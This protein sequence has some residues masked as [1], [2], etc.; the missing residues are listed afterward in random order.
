MMRYQVFSNV[1][2]SGATVQWEVT[3]RYFRLLS[4]TAALKIATDDAE[5]QVFY[6]GIGA[7]EPDG[8]K[9]LR[10][11]NEKVFAV[12]FELAA[13][14]GPVS[15]SRFTIDGGLPVKAGGAS[16]S[17]AEID[18]SNVAVELLAA[19]AGRTSCVI[20]AGQ[21]GLWLGPTKAVQV[22]A[23]PTVPAGQSLTIGHRGAVWA[24]RAAG[25]A[26]KAGV[27]TEVE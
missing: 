17:F 23:V 11:V 7:N 3:G 25:G 8:F 12:G 16:F 14:D 27:Y 24:I 26:V 13:A 19:D 18:V 2:A 4:A 1:L 5:P 15:D 6:P 20:Q 9:S 22:G 21:T 10:I